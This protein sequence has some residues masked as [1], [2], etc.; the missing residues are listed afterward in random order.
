MISFR[1]FITGTSKAMSFSL[2]GSSSSKD[3]N[4]SVFV[5]IYFLYKDF[6]YLSWLKKAFILSLVSCSSLLIMCIL[7]GS[8]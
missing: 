6:I 5:S 1:Y 8:V 2:S 3:T 7:R 4:S